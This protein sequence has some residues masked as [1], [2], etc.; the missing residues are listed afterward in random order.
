M[1]TLLHSGIHMDYLKIQVWFL[2]CQH[3]SIPN[4]NGSDY[5]HQCM[6]VFKSVIT[7]MMKGIPARME[8]KKWMLDYV[9]ASKV[10]GHCLQP[11][12]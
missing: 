8:S 1:A 3:Q 12:V 9:I 11:L 4:Q 10:P 5:Q 6:W 2:S 7:N